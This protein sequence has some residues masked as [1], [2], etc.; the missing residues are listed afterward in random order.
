MAD[1]ETI[2]EKPFASLVT[3]QLIVS[4]ECWAA[5]EKSTPQKHL[6]LLLLLLYHN[7]LWNKPTHTFTHALPHI[8]HSRNR[9]ERTEQQQLQL[10]ANFHRFIHK[11]AENHRYPRAKHKHNKR[12]THRSGAKRRGYVI[13]R[14][15]HV[16]CMLNHRRLWLNPKRWAFCLFIRSDCVGVGRSPPLF[17]AS[18]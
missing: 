1:T 7:Y 4:A 10:A 12:K 15:A 14:R 11:R 16:N 17:V 2:R 18:T 8:G 3:G 9:I 6:L 13:W 5:V